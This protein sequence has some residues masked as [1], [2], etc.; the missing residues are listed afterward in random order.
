MT[1]EELYRR[2]VDILHETFE[3]PKERITWDAHLVNDLDLDSIDAVDLIVR[4]KPL[5]GK[6]LTPEAFQQV[7]TVRDVVKALHQLING[8]GPAAPP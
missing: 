1:E 3:L 7:R 2:C 5:I 6:R 4:M 8:D